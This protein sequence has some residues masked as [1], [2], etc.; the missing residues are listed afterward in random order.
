[1]S[2]GYLIKQIEREHP[3]FYRLLGPVFGSREIA[4]ALGWSLYD[5]PEKV[6]YVAL[7]GTTLAGFAAY[8]L[9]KSGKAWLCSAYVFPEHRRRG[10]YDA[11]FR[12]RLEALRNAG[13]KHVRAVLTPH[14]IHTAERYRFEWLADRGQYKMYGRD[15]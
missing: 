8:R 9:T 12:V 13:A 14:S 5:D 15:L 7:H 6:W 4:K 3:D 11:L 2:E 10:L 1:M